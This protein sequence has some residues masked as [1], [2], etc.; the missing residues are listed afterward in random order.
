MGKNR[1]W[2]KNIVRE[3]KQVLVNIY[4]EGDQGDQFDTTGITVEQRA[5][6]TINNIVSC[7]RLFL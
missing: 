4:Y 5:T 1:P 6:S 2:W 7:K 3:S